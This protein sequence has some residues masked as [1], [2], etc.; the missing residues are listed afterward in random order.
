[1]TCG[2]RQEVVAAGPASRRCAFQLR[3]RNDEAAAIATG[4]GI[5]VVQVRCLKIEHARFHGRLHLRRLR[6]FD[7]VLPAV[8]TP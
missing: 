7:V 8:Q 6:H 4:A 2:R 3:L 5:T 1:M